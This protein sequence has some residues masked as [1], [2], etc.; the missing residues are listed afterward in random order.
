MADYHYYGGAD[1]GGTTEEK[2]KRAKKRA[3]DA[4]RDRAKQERS[5]GTA[6]KLLGSGMAGRAADKLKARKRKH[7]EYWDTL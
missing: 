2:R 4:A 6:R 3:D 7:D 1:G 5:K